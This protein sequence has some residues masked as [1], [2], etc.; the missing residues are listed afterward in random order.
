VRVDGQRGGF[1]CSPATRSTVKARARVRPQNAR[2][3]SSPDR[4]NA[5][6]TTGIT[7][8]VRRSRCTVGGL[9]GTSWSAD[10]PFR[11]ELQ[12]RRR[13]GVGP[14][15][16]RPMT[17]LRSARFARLREATRYRRSATFRRY[18]AAIPTQPEPPGAD[19]GITR[20]QP[21]APGHRRKE[22]SRDPSG[23]ADQAQLAVT[24]S[25]ASDLMFA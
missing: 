7:A 3:G 18:L 23:V 20:H 17:D 19:Q 15:D 4:E 14:R 21:L 24:K 16:R 6:V 2:F 1:S 11:S 12:P 5:A 10:C 8:S 22:E 13:F 9:G 25:P